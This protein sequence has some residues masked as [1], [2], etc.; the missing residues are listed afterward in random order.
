MTF[1][2]LQLS[3]ASAITPPDI[4]W[5]ALLPVLILC[6]AGILLLTV[7]SVVPK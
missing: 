4:A 3:L 5:S 1:L 2:T 7:V 6:G